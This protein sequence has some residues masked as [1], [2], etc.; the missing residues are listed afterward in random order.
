M[1]SVC[2]KIILE[3]FIEW[4]KDRDRKVAIISIFENIRDIPYAI[5]PELRDPNSGPAGLL[6]LRKG[7]CQPKHFLLA[8]LFK[9]L[10]I[11]VKYATYPFYWDKQLIKYPDNLKKIVKELPSAYHL[12]CKAYINDKWILV[13][14]THDLALKKGGFTVNEKW[15]GI[16][17]T[18]N[19]VK[20]YTE[21][22]HETVKE[23]V[24]YEAR[25][26][27]LYTERQ[28]TLYA[29]FVEKFNI[30]LENLRKR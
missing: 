9:K 5:I 2:E 19:A 23:R 16:S 15:D 7:S 25:Q 4:T 12:A 14:A 6:N 11:P 27:S 10:N 30:W 17:D 3:K 24:E 26:K 18:I 22:L 28:K 1:A 20:P 8:E 21:V 13:D 29:E